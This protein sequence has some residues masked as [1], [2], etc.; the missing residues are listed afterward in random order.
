MDHEE[1]ARENLEQTHEEKARE[2]VESGDAQGNDQAKLPGEQ[3][4]S[5]E[6]GGT[7]DPDGSDATGDGPTGGEP[8]TG[9]SG[10]AAPLTGSD[11]PTG[12][13]E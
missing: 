10:N 11:G 12:G 8:T 9:T 7:A 13:A 3:G 5:H 1:R 2:N 6:A 4:N